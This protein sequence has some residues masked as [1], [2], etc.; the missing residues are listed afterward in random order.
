MSQS[1]DDIFEGVAGEGALRRFQASL[2]S[3]NNSVATPFDVDKALEA[4]QAFE[5]PLNDKTNRNAKVR[6]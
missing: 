1:T 3:S 5:S 4:F 2:D 6:S